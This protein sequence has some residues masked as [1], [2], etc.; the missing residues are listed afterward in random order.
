MHVDGLLDLIASEARLDLVWLHGLHALN[1]TD[2]HDVNDGEDNNSDS[3]QRENPN[4]LVLIAS[5]VQDDLPGLG[6]GLGLGL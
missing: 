1:G 6:L 4:V 3:A 5:D 2:D